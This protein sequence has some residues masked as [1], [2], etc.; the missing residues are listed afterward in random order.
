MFETEVIRWR[1]GILPH[2]AGRQHRGTR[3]SAGPAPAAGPSGQAQGH[4]SSPLGMTAKNRTS[5]DDYLDTHRSFW[6]VSKVGFYDPSAHMSSARSATSFIP[7]VIAGSVSRHESSGTIIAAP[8]TTIPRP[9]GNGS[10]IRSHVF[11]SRRSEVRAAHGKIGTP[12]I[13]ANFAA[14]SAATLRGPLGPSG[15][16]PI[17]ALSL[18]IRTS[19][20]KP[21]APPREDDPCTGSIP[22]FLTIFPTNCPSR[23]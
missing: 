5:R 21:P 15:V 6:C 9:N 1:H 10:P 8:Q 23:C 3:P 18:I 16:I 12:A 11:N 20:R 22:K 2:F 19:W 4:D 13:A 14:P 7:A 17:M